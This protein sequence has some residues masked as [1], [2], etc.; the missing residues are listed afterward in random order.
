[1]RGTTRLRRV[2]L[3]P[4][5]S[6]DRQVGTVERMVAQ[7]VAFVRWTDGSSGT[8]GEDELVPSEDD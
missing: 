6:S 2:R 1:V 3:N 7:D 8:Y 4:E 5:H